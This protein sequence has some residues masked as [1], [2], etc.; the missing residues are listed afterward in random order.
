MFFT[1]YV[2]HFYFMFFYAPRGAFC[3]KFFQ[4][5]FNL[6]LFF[7]IFYFVSSYSFSFFILFP[8][9]RLTAIG[10]INWSLHSVANIYSLETC[11][12]KQTPHSNVGF[13]GC[14][15]RFTGPRVLGGRTN[16]TFFYKLF[17]CST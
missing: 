2:E 4:F 6:H 17:L 10:P 9:I 1:L 7:F 5:I 16:H 11:T 12:H 14:M 8:V 13:V 15:D 3:F